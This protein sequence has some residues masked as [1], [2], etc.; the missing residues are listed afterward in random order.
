MRTKRS[1]ALLTAALLAAAA[2]TAC[3]KTPQPDPSSAVT[4]ES[5]GSI[6]APDNTAPAQSTDAADPSATGTAGA[7]TNAAGT[8]AAGT[9]GTKRP[10]VG[11]TAAA[12]TKAPTAATKVF[13]VESY[14]AKGDGKTDD[15]PAITKA[16]DAAMRDGSAQKVIE[17]SA[18]KTYRVASNGVTDNAALFTVSEADGITVRGSN[19]RLLMKAPMRVCRVM[20]STDFVMTG[21]IVDYS[22]KPF[23]I[24]TVKNVAGDQSY[25]DIASDTDLGVSGTFTPAN[26]DYFMFRNKTDE[27]MHVFISRVTKNSDG[28]YRFFINTNLT[29]TALIRQNVPVGMEM[30]VPVSGAAHLQNGI[31]QFTGTKNITM[32]NVTINAAPD[33]VC[34]MRRCTGEITFKN[35]RLEPAAGSPALVSWRDGFHIKDNRAKLTWDNCTIGPLGDDAFNI[36]SVI[37]AI[38]SV[39]TSTGI[40]NMTPAED[41]ADRAGLIMPGD[42]IV[43]YDLRGGASDAVTCTITAV[44]NTAGNNIAVKVDADLSKIPNINTRYV[45]FYAMNKGYEIKNCTV[46]GTVRLRSSGT[47]TNTKFDVFWVRVENESA[48]EGPVPKNITFKDCTF[49]TPY[50]NKNTPVLVINSQKASGGNAKFLVKNI[51][52]DGCVFQGCT[53]DKGIHELILKD[54]TQR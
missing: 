5:S 44:L 29:S 35:V 30:I 52:C 43:I 32:Q 51:V 18:N 10:G 15:G 39:N 47:V 8:T 19:T 2:L 13:K 40:I 26:R 49:S 21:L 7:G 16:L 38:D 36:S 17:F 37:C 3:G 9:T 46:E 22:P 34:G 33:F 54:C 11:T 27:R 41:T 4:P 20:D 42:E 6:S 24:G 45:G 28:T 53:Y 12:T 25:V 31:M 14:G 50:S 23:A 1:I 48:V